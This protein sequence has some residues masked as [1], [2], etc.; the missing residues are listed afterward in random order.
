M[1]TF[2][3]LENIEGIQPC[4]VALGNFDGVH[5]GH[6]R[7]IRETVEKAKKLGIRSGVFTFSSHPKNMLPGQK[8]KN[9]LYNDEK[10]EII[11][12]LGVD[13]LFNI[14]FT[15]EIMMMSP[16]DFIDRLLIG[17][18]NLREAFC[19]F[20]YHFGF[21]ALGNP[22]LLRNE[23]KKKAFN[24]N[25]MEPFE[26]DGKV[27]SSTLVRELIKKGDM[28]ECTKF[29]GRNYEIKAEVVVGNKLGRTLGFPT[30][31]LMIDNNMVSPPNGVYV[32]YCT[33]NG[34]KYDSITNVGVKPTIGV[35]TKNVETH[36]FDFDK[37]IYG[38]NII[39]EFIEKTRDEKKFD[40]VQAL[41]AQVIQDC[42]D[43]KKYHGID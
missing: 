43:A 25:E 41:S 11:E 34:K 15:K 37:E 9:I 5:L 35:Y 32:T 17:K 18:M 29:L 22:E 31:N 6:Q 3:T 20:N 33:Y 2:D 26:I 4:C 40:S 36:I 13:Y 38:K 30:S 12:S 16:T 42:M 21:K 39:V 1:K 27:V 8:V 23:G 24:V 28:I 10:A 14:K 7:L 19:G